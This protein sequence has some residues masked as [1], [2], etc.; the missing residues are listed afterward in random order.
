[1]PNKARWP[2][3]GLPAAAYQRIIEAVR[4]PAGL[5]R[6]ACTVVDQVELFGLDVL[7]ASCQEITTLA[8]GAVLSGTVR[9]AVGRDLVLT[10][11]AAGTGMT[12]KSTM[13]MGARMRYRAC[14]DVHLILRC[15]E[16]ILLGQRQNTRFAD[17]S[18]H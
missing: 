10:P 13:E 16:E 17:G 8:S 2:S 12:S 11:P 9:C 1:L 7:P 14:V 4:W 5:G 18:W 3:P 6:E 15:G